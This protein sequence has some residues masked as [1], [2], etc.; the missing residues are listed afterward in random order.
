AGVTQGFVLRAF[1]LDGTLAKEQTFSGLPIRIGRNAL[2][3]FE[4]TSSTV[5]SFH[6][7]IDYEDGRLWLHDLN[8]RNGI[9]T[10]APADEES[11]RVDPEHGTELIAAE[12]KIILGHQLWLR[13][14]RA[15]LPVSQREA[16]RV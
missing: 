11:V 13:L 8:S 5:S 15:H 6:A 3:D 12:T 2:N 14:D 7:R 4:L 16:A 10:R 1:Y 9:F